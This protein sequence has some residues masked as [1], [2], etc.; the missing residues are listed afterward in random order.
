M[1]ELKI[2][3]EVV[4]EEEVRLSTSGERMGEEDAGKAESDVDSDIFDD[5]YLDEYCEMTNM[6]EPMT[7]LKELFYTDEMVKRHYEKLSDEDKA[8]FDQMKEL[9]ERIKQE[10]GDYSLIE[11]V[12]Y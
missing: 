12:M 2:K 1:A 6:L 3:Q 9:A 4:E 5:E 10:T 7:I 11:D 8:H